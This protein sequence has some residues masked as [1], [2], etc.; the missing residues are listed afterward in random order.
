M[1][2]PPLFPIFLLSLFVLPISI[3][4]AI[5][6]SIYVKIRPY[7][8]QNWP[9]SPL[10][11]RKRV[12]LTGDD[13]AAL[14][15]AARV[16][17]A[18]GSTVYVI[19]QERIPHTNCLWTS[20]AIHRYVGLAS[21]RLTPILRR[22]T[23]GTRFNLIPAN[24][25]GTT[26]NLIESEKIDLWMH[27]D[28]GRLSTAHLQTKE[29]VLK[30]STTRLFEPE[31]DTARLARG[32]SLFAHH[33]RQHE[34]EVSCPKTIVVRSRAEIHDILWKAPKHQQF[35]LERSVAPYITPTKANSGNK[36]VSSLDDSATLVEG[37][38]SDSDDFE[39][40]ETSTPSEEY[41]PLPQPTSNETYSTVALL[42]VSASSPW[43]LHEVVTGRPGTICTLVVKGKVA[44]FAAQTA[45][46]I[47]SFS[48]ASCR[49]PL[50]KKKPLKISADWNIKDWQ[51]HEETHLIDPSSTIGTALLRFAERFVSS[52]SDQ[53][54]TYLNLH[55]FLTDRSTGGGAEQKIVATGCDF[56]FSPVLAENALACG[57]AE[58]LGRA[59]T[60]GGGVRFEDEVLVLPKTFGSKNDASGGRP[61]ITLPRSAMARGESLN[62]IANTLEQLINDHDAIYD[63]KDLV[64]WIWSWLVQGTIETAFEGVV[65]LL[66][67]TQAQV[68]KR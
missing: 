11:L 4:L 10:A 32:Y 25:P 18:S 8:I 63:R 3:W 53:P 55:F 58:D 56:N 34:N 44:A 24:L 64:P 27:C 14:L 54:S 49:S 62:A 46:D 67:N 5:T 43:I 68:G 12:L 50:S 59:M 29:I 61:A 28:G 66:E 20:K 6:L 51:Q 35:V 22:L 30:H 45:N 33:M 9:S 38:S 31:L 36:R 13:D 23:K 16:L 48:T 57:V 41:T 1:A 65:E 7:Y 39:D 17:R 21:G 2:P 47:R 40:V 42:Q 19:K 52:L 26:L 37:M 60:G 15:S